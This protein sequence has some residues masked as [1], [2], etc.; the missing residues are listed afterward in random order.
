MSENQKTYVVGHKNPDTD[1]I[2]S[3]ICY[4]ELKKKITGENY[5]ARRAG[6][7]NEETQYV[8]DYFNVDA[9]EILE[10]VYTQVSDIQVMKL[11]GV[12]SNIS[13]KKAYTLM[14]SESVTTLPVTDANGRYGIQNTHVLVIHGL[15]SS[16]RNMTISSLRTGL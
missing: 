6:N 7:V 4:A 15:L 12:S 1:S 5:E 2:C 16:V 13:M 8:L 10:N 3:A 14:K 11:N 9:P